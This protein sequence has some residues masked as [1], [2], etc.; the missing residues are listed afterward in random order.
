MDIKILIATHKKYNMPNESFYLPI[1]VGSEGKNDLGYIRDN[2]GINISKKNDNYCELTGLYW[3]WKNIDCDYLGLVH[4]RR[5]FSKKS[6]FYRIMNGK[7][8]SILSQK[9]LEGLVKNNDII[10][11]K[12]RNYF[13]ESIYSHYAHTHYAEHLDITRKII[14]ND[15][16]EYLD[17]FDK[18]MVSR[19]A[20]MFNMLIM[21]KR[22]LDEYCQWLFEV[23]EKLEDCIDISEYDAFQARLF[24]R[25]SEILL[26]VW[27]EKN[28]LEYK[29]IGYIHLG[30]INWLKKVISFFNAKYRN[31]KFEGSF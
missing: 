7:E 3:A 11:P 10:L 30:K 16:P 23:L 28:K 1:Q 22:I 19:S 14:K 4:Y 24:G 27:I 20:H 8:K 12:K 26:N 5:H 25:V 21:K 13:I 18:V 6:I 31:K 9:E 29:E 2:T 17:S 15:M